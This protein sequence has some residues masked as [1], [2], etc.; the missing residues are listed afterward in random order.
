MKTWLPNW[1]REGIEGFVIP[2]GPLW[3]ELSSDFT[4]QFLM[5]DLTLIV[6]NID[7][8]PPDDVYFQLPLFHPHW[9]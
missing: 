8:I 2:N 4:A 6:I 3:Q 7:N 5:F 1:G 9:Y